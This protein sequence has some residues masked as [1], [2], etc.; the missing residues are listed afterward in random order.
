M[1]SIN[2]QIEDELK[3]TGV[4]FIRFLDVSELTDAQ[5]R[6]LPSAILIGISIDPKFIKEVFDNP[7]YIP[8]HGD[9]Y[10]QTEEKAGEVT[11]KLAK[12]LADKGHKAISQSDGGLIADAAFNFDKKESVLPHKTVAVLGG[13]GWIGKN[14]LLITPEYG[15]AQC[16]GT[17]L[18]DAPL[19]TNTH[20]RL[21]P[22]CGNCRIC[23]DICEKKV[24]KGKGWDTTVSRDE[25][26]DVHGC[27]ICLK[28]LVHCPQ[29][30]AY[31]KRSL[32]GAK[33]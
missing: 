21:L 11:D 4:D 20:E 17:L 33:A 27:S 32:P 1:K 28:C 3:N 7:D 8:T 10:I 15:A 19:E 13:L 9:E 31:M 25:I 14:N 26:V 2:H 16:L 23:T 22:Q 24:L 30:Q 18:T 6:G 5:N 12:I 29:T